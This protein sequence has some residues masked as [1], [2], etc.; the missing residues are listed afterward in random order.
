[1]PMR[2]IL[3]ATL[4]AL[5]LLAAGA[6]PAPAGSGRDRTHAR[7]VGTPTFFVIGRGWGHGIGLS[8][9][10]A[11]GY[12]QH[13]FRADAIVTHYYRGTTI[14]QAP[15]SRVRVLLGDGRK[16]VTIASKQPFAVKDG[17]GKSHPLDAGTY[18]VG[19][20]FKVRD[21]PT[22]P[23]HTIPYPLV[24]VPGQQ[25]LALDGRGYRGSIQLNKRASSLQVVNVV[26][27]EPYLWG[28]VPW[29]MPRDWSPEALKAQAIVARSYAV[30]HI[31][32]GG[33]YDLFPDTRSQM[34]GGIRAEAPSSNSAV[35]QTA[36]KVV[37]YHGKVADTMFF[38]TSG[39]RT[40]SVQDVWP[41]ATP[42]PYLTSVAD[43]YDSISPY[44]VWGPLR[45]PSSTLAR[46]LRVPGKLI[47]IDISAARSGRVKNLIATGS[48]G[49][50]TL[51]GWNVR[52]TLGLRSTW[53]RIASLSLAPPT[54][55]VAYGASA[56][57][58]GL[59]RGV[60]SATLQQRPFGGSWRAVG[61]VRPAPD[62]S[63]SPSVAPK[64]SSDYRLY[65]AGITSTAVRLSVAPL[66]RLFAAG[67]RSGFYGRV[68][69]VLRGSVRIQ[70]QTGSTWRTLARAPVRADGTFVSQAYPEAGTYRARFVPTPSTGYVVGIS[71]VL[72]IVG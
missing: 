30:A 13:G 51:T 64:V 2:S 63:V 70:R 53:F 57:L 55:P 5:G 36:G 25:P 28:V 48:R 19:T 1:M 52:E 38:S 27:L 3:T 18:N 50:V 26:G 32:R 10:G 44:H 60:A 61:T 71:P 59:A 72:R 34:Y 14:G 41:G 22:T 43:P 56:E 16:R 7:A 65:A 40:A 58:D 66:V 62:G 42:I 9:Y 39:G 68:R 31:H 69:P 67:D 6:G 15:L 24:F 46:R 21:D 29:E 11:Y 4:A 33:T 54:A 20:S 47:S 45:M 8:Q 37:L 17:A 23:P 12:A 49:Q 35:N